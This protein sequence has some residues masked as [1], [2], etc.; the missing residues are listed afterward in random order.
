MHIVIERVCRDTRLDYAKTTWNENRFHSRFVD[1]GGRPAPPIRLTGARMRA[2]RPAVQ[3]SASL[4]TIA[5]ALA[6]LAGGSLAACST[7]T[8]ATTSHD[9]RVVQVVAA[10]NFW[11]SIA[12]Q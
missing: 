12:S 4:V 7:A 2:T 10:E 9:S 1:A 11:G 3:R 5:A 8:G 6:V